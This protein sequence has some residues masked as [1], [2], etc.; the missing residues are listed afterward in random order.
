MGLAREQV[1]DTAIFAMPHASRSRLVRFVELASRNFRNVIVIPDLAGIITPS[2]VMA[3][4]LA[5]TFG[6]EVK[7]NLLNPWALRAKRMLDLVGVVVGGL[8]ISPLLLTIAALIKLTS[9]GPVFYAQ[10]RLGS[11]N[12]HFRCWKFRTM[13][14]D[15]DFYLTDLLQNNPKLRSE[16]ERNQKLRSDPRVTPFGCFLRKTSLDEVPQLWN[17]LR[18]E[19]S[20]IGPRPIVDAEVP[21]YSNIYQL[22]QRVKPGISGLWQVSGRNDTGYEERVALDAHYVRNWSVWLDIVILARTVASV[23]FCRGAF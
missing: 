9:P 22:Y 11:E 17:V 13:Y 14:A 19:M 1:A 7:Y 23:I 21:K 2:A 8:L 20:L 3:R 15:A 6:V 18:G 5:G 12:K 10:Q 4:D 16:W